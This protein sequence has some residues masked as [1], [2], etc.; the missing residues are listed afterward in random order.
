MGLFQKS[1]KAPKRQPVDRRESLRSIP[2][3]IPGVTF[4][5]EED[6]RL[7]VLVPIR[8]RGGFLGYFQSPAT[9]HRIRLDEIGA[10]VVGIIDGERTVQSIVDAFAGKYRVNK[11]EAEL[12]IAAFLKSLAQRN[13]IAIGIR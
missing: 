10:Y 5:E 8:R 1:D 13:V 2:A 12:S 6:G 7:T 9:K 3:I 4:E 11:R